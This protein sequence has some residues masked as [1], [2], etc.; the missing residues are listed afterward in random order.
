MG[1]AGGGTRSLLP[2]REEA[3]MRDISPAAGG[4]LARPEKVVLRKP[5]VIACPLP[6]R[7]GRMVLDGDDAG[8]HLVVDAGLADYH[9]CQRDDVLNL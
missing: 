5:A 1:I 8:K 6:A 7:A 3:R 9:P 4:R 2:L